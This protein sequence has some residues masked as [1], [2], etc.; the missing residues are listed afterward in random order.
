MS[1][2]QSGHDGPETD[3]QED[4][5][6]STL[7]EILHHVDPKAGLEDWGPQK[8]VEKYLNKREQ[9]ISETTYEEYEDE[10]TEFV[11][12]CETRDIYPLNELSKAD[13]KELNE[14][15]RTEVPVQVDQYGS[16]TTRDFIYVVRNFVRFLENREVVMDGLHTKLEPPEL[17]DGDGV[18]DDVLD[19]DRAQEIL[20]HLSTY[21][22]AT[23]E[24]AVWVLLA[25]FGGRRGTIRAIDLEDCHLREE[26]LDD[27]EKPYIEL[28]HRPEQGTPLKN[29]EK[30]ERE[31]S[32][33]R[34]I[35]DVL[36]DYI[37]VNREDETDEYGR[38]PLIT[39][40]EGRI[41]PST[42]TK[43]AYKWTRPCKVSGDCP[44]GRS[45]A[46]C[47][48]ARNMDQA[49]KCPSSKSPHPS[50]KGYITEEA[51]AGVPDELLSERCDV[52][53]DVLEEHY[54]PL[55]E[56]EKRELRQEMLE[57]I[58]EESDGYVS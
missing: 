32:I 13:M 39:T 38:E 41:V 20:D 28:K 9:E 57:A 33:D 44:H 6:Q 42:I 5:P 35:A 24:H 26:E 50:R 37:A 56:T 30:S 1:E 23:V 36:L 2:A 4:E 58:R 48:A 25:A 8:G 45:E 27:G 55:N 46:D 31:V 21:E 53:I 16:K 40:D 51:K 14:W 3:P 15:Y 11:E 18:S 43:Y 29:D 12:Y 17:D 34:W 47:E 52:G 22:H 19:A 49:S 10:L 7:E 54:K